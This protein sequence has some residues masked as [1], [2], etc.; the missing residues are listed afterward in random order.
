MAPAFKVLN[1]STVAAANPLE[2]FSFAL[3]T[4]SLCEIFETFVNL[5]QIARKC[6][7]NDKDGLSAD[8]VDAVQCSLVVELWAYIL[9]RSQCLTVFAIILHPKID[10][11]CFL[12]SFD[13][14][15]RCR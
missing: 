10:Y 6:V 1:K 11:G 3:G 7:L 13:S 5:F 12:S 2:K 15:F 14:S 9:L 8:S 4:T